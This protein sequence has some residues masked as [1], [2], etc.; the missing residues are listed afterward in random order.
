MK[1]STKVIE[2]MAELVSEEMGQYSEELAEEG[3]VMAIEEEMRE[4]LRQVGAKGLGK[5]LSQQE[6]RKERKHALACKCG[7]QAEYQRQREAVVMSVFG[8]VHFIRG[9]YLC[10]H[11]H[12]GQAPLDRELHLRAGGVTAG[13]GSL[14]A[15]AGVEASFEEGQRKIERYLRIRVSDNTIRKETELFGRLQAEEEQEWKDK[16]QDA[17]YLQEQVRQAVKREER[18]YGS[19]DGVMTP[20]KGEWR[21]LK[22]ISWYQAE[23]VSRSK[24]R[25]HHGQRSQE[26]AEMQTKNITYATDQQDAESFGKLVWATG[27]QREVGHYAEIVFIADGAAWI[28]RLVEQYYPNAVQI[29]DWYHACEYLAPIAQTAFPNDPQQRQEWLE[30]TRELLW[31][32]QIQAVLAACRAVEAQAPEPVRK[33]LSYYTNNEKRMNYAQLRQQGYLIGSGTVESACKQIALL[34]LCCAGARWSKDGLVQTAKA[35][36][37]WL[38]DAWDTL[39]AKRARLPLAA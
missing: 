35:R 22:V 25:R 5:V 16:S 18:I 30:Q 7:Q 36:A 28:W 32:G 19:L 27:C 24:P 23:R 37:A 34:R 26:Q 17:A 29:V 1:F 15:L 31:Q 13:L 9:Y 4:V 11:C 20:L 39:S 3:G 8:R 2:K 21:E 12:Q 6:E 14:L 10:R 33:A 38:S